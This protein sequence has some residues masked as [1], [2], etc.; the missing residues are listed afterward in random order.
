MLVKVPSGMTESDLARPVVEILDFETGKL[1]YEIYSYGEETVVIPVTEN[2]QSSGINKLAEET[3]ETELRKYT[4][5]VEAEMVSN[6]RA[7]V[8]VPERDIAR[9]IGQQGRNIESIEKNLGISL[10]V[11][12][13]K[14]DEVVDFDLDEDAK[15]I[16]FFAEAGQTVDLYIDGEFAVTA[17]TSKKGEIKVHKKSELGRRLLKAIQKKAKIE[18][19]G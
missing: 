10:D 12:E 19:R 11:R 9:I 15:N 17:I 4:S 2:K 14:K 7:I 8:Y 13:L 1:E 6:N 18:L 16:R 5:S 3:I